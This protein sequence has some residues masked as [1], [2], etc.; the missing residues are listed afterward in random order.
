MGSSV[1]PNILIDRTGNA[2][3]ADFGLLTITSD[4]TNVTSS[5]SFWEGGT[6]RW[7][8]PEM[9]CPKKFGLKDNRPT[10]S[11]DCYALEMVVYEVLRGKV[12]FYRDTNLF[13]VVKV[14][15]GEQ[16]KRPQGAKGAWFGD[17]VWNLLQR[18]WEPSPGDRPGIEDVLDLL[19]DVSRSWTPPPQIIDPQTEVPTTSDEEPSTGESTDEC[20]LVSSQP[21]Q[22]RRLGGNS[23]KNIVCPSTH[24]PSAPSKDAPDHRAQRTTV[25]NLGG[26]GKSERIP[27]RVSWVGHFD[28]TRVLTW[29][30]ARHNSVAATLRRPHS[31]DGILTT[32]GS[33][34]PHVT[35]PG[36]ESK[37]SAWRLWGGKIERWERSQRR[38]AWF[39]TYPRMSLKWRRHVTK[40]LL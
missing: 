26:S 7:M 10:K 3:L 37:R 25:E 13:V 17:N 1:K 4:A 24:H 2:C 29:R 35:S 40:V 12:P 23:N 33:L 20:E 30:P 9:F 11:S 15:D 8:G 38:F 27:E 31:G 39:S 18:C 14:S 16:P 6:W 22:R 36:M 28:S 19:G 34:L 21:S 5:N 32:I